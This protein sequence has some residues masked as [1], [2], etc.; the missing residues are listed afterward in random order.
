MLDISDFEI[1]NPYRS[2]TYL[3]YR[4]LRNYLK[5]PVKN[6]DA[7]LEK[8]NVIKTFLSKYRRESSFLVEFYTSECQ[9]V[10]EIIDE[11]ANE[12]DD[13]KWRFYPEIKLPFLNSKNEALYM[14]ADVFCEYEPL[15]INKISEKIHTEILKDIP[16]WYIKNIKINKENK[17]VLEHGRFYIPNSKLDP[18]WQDNPEKIL[19]VSDIEYKQDGDKA[20]IPKGSFIG[21][22]KEGGNFCIES[23]HRN[24][25]IEEQAKIATMYVNFIEKYGSEHYD[26]RKIEDEKSSIYTMEEEVEKAIKESYVHD[27]KGFYEITSLSNADEIKEKVYLNDNFSEPLKC[28]IQN[29]DEQ[30]LSFFIKKMDDDMKLVREEVYEQMKEDHAN[31]KPVACYNELIFREGMSKSLWADFDMAKLM[32]DKI[33]ETRNSPSK[34]T[35]YDKF[36]NE[37]ADKQNND[38]FRRILSISGKADEISKDLKQTIERK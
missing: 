14:L 25:R 2:E 31:C 15:K 33:F 12:K 20:I 26:H 10:K 17:L 4:W 28:F 9:D 23:L 6:L 34:P 37:I 32:M 19:V 7:R 1:E 5:D 35:L 13:I 27:L 3:N 11:I 22:T 16:I 21:L 18:N 38:Y 29:L 30:E 8:K 24:E 36:L